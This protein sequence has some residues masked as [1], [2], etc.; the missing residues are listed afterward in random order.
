[1]AKNKNKEEKGIEQ[2]EESL[3][4]AEKFV[5]KNKNSITYSL[6]GVLLIIIAVMAYN[7]YI[8]EPKIV[9]A[10]DAI[11]PAQK[12]FYNDSLELALFGNDTVVGFLDIIDDYKFTN[13]ANLANFYSGQCY[14]HLSRTDTTVNKEDYLNEAIN[15]LS[16]YKADD[17]IT[18]SQAI[19][20]IG[21]ANLELGN[22]EKGAK[23]YIEAA[24]NN[25]DDFTSPYYLM[26]AGKTY[27]I[28]GN[29]EKALEIFKRVKTE[30]HNSF[31]AREIKKYIA[32]EEAL[33]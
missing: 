5:E 21:D 4:K 30:Y 25:E 14:I 2:F 31:E 8:R 12:N 13:S 29:H 22:L 9:E 11:Y 27:S 3:G 23:K 20:L 6:M 7:K 10:H 28:L 32:R 18:S 24:N 26:K 17:L 16:K 1:M 19:G 15:H 33:L